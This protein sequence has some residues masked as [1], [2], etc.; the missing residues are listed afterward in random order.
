MIAKETEG[1]IVP[2][3]LHR[4]AE[5]AG[6]PRLNFLDGHRLPRLYRGISLP[7]I[8]LDKYPFSGIRGESRLR[9]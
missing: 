1:I 5:T 6:R 9:T 3:A 2:G 8:S 4:K 7:R